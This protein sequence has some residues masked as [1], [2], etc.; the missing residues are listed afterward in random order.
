[1]VVERCGG[2][3]GGRGM[4]GFAAFL[5][6]LVQMVRLRDLCGTLVRTLMFSAL[7]PDAA[8]EAMDSAGRSRVQ[9]P[10]SRTISP[11]VMILR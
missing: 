8:H 9:T 10:D 6:S 4:A 5:L 2:E 7:N 3:I 1:L 11:Y